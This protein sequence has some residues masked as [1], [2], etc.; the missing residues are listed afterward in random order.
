MHPFQ[1]PSRRVHGATIKKPAGFAVIVTLF[2]LLVPSVL[3][4]T[5]NITVNGSLFSP[6]TQ[7][8]NTGDTVVWQNADDL[9]SHTTTSDLSPSNPNY[10]NGLLVNFGDTF[11]HTFNNVGTFTYHDQSD[12]GTGSITVILPAPPMILLAAPRLNGTQFVFDATGLTVSK[13]NV[14]QASTNLTSWVAITTNVAATSSLT[15]TNA[16][17]L[18]RRFFRL[19]ELP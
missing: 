12:T 11:S 13:T 6:A 9:F 16:T 17:A 14:L 4:T 8:I 18:P 15:F 1:N 3:A 7:T 19:I 5:Y 2:L 10:W